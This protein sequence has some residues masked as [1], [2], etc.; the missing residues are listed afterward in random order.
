MPGHQGP[1]PQ[2]GR[3][4][5][6]VF[7]PL[8]PSTSFMV[9]IVPFMKARAVGNEQTQQKQPQNLASR[10][11]ALVLCSVCKMPE[12]GNSVFSR[13]GRTYQHVDTCLREECQPHSLYQGSIC[14]LLTLLIQTVFFS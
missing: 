14:L 6:A 5:S 11:R 3:H 12:D 2:R 9:L 7:P 1:Q 13:I 10:Y 4:I 8:S